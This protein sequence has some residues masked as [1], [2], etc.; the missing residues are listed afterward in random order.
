[1]M[2]LLSG[3]SLANNIFVQLYTRKVGVTF[4]VSG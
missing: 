1:M 2:L 4:D 3:Q